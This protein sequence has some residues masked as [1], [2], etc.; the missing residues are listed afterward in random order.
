[1]LHDNILNLARK[2]CHGK[3]LSHAHWLRII[4]SHKLNTM[5]TFSMSPASEKVLMLEG[6]NLIV[7]NCARKLMKHKT[8]NNVRFYKHLPVTAQNR[9]FVPQSDTNSSNFLTPH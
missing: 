7:Y 9:E 2:Q 8:I 3:T 6:E 5:T 1:M 4:T